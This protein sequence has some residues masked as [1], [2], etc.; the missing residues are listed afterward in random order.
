MYIANIHIKNYRCFEDVEVEFQP[1]I[2]V[3]IGE[4]NAG[5]SALIKALGLIFNRHNRSSIDL[6]DFHQGI[7]DYSK[8]PEIEIK[9]TLKSSG[10]DTEEDKALVAT[11]LTKL[12]SPWEAQL[13]YK[14]FLSEDDVFKF[15]EKLGDSADKIKYWNLVEEYLPKYISQIYGGNPSSLIKAE[16]EYLRKF[17]F[18]FLDAIRD[19]ESQMFSGTNPLLKAM[20][21][22]VLDNGIDEDQVNKNREEFAGLSKSALDNLLSRLDSKKLLALVEG[23]GAK[24]GGSPELSGTISEYDFITSLKLF[25]RRSDFILPANYNG[26]GYNN[27]VYISL[28][29]ASLDF[30]S[31]I[32][33]RGPNAV[34]FPMLLIEEPEAHLHPALQYKLLKFIQERIRD[35]KSSRQIFI[36]THS[37]QITAA[38]GLDPI[39]C[40]SISDEENVQVSYPGKVFS[41]DE[42]GKRSKRYIERYLDAT[43]SNM[44]FSKGIIFVEGIAEQLLLP[45]FANYIGSSLEEKHVALI[46]VGGLTFKH[47]L[48]IFGANVAQERERF[49]L[50]RKV[51][52]IVDADPARKLKSGGK[53]KKCH[54]YQIDVEEEKYEYYASSGVVGNLNTMIKGC[55]NIKICSGDKTLEYDI[56]LCNDCCELLLTPELPSLEDLRLFI[57]NQDNGLRELLE[58]D[59]MECLEAISDSAKKKEAEFATYYLKCAEGLKGEH[60]LMLQQQLNENF[61]KKEEDRLNF[62]VPPYIADAIRWACRDE[63]QEDADS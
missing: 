9:V 36:T 31:S 42:S 21:Q 40:F 2:S 49:V 24:D 32:E 11:W 60:A 38:S 44:L 39:V 34:I 41:D 10:K 23:T 46:G 5:K 58:D 7:K 27:L 17:D 54:P 20:L 19:V 50:N 33:K 62:E 43:K 6:F 3:I 61:E 30:Q 25:I 48:P 8:P 22:Q 35:S 37:T 1:G 45:S 29:L 47:F 15:K 52:C 14:Y 4:N 57:Q 56:A 63:E 12:V 59:E 51:A 53:R 28:L 13:T 18:Q 16:P 26:L 55:D